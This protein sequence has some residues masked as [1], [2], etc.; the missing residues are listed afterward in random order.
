MSFTPLLPASGIV[1][2]RLLTA[3]E[4][5]QRAAFDRQPQIARDVAYFEEKIGAV[6]T[7][8]DLVSDRRLL[9]VALGAFGLDDE[10]DK[11]AYL[12]R[13]L[14]DGTEASDALANKLVDPRYKAFSKAFGFG[15][16]GG[17]RVARTGF[18]EGLTAA[19]RERQFEIAVGEQDD[20]LRLALNFRREITRHAN[21]P[22]PEGVAWFSV[23]GDQPLRAV[24]EGALGLPT[25]FG[26]LDIDRQRDDLRDKSDRVFGSRSLAIF[27]D[28]EKV[29]EA[30]GRFLARRAAEAGPSPLTPGA[31][32]LTVLQSPGGIGSM[33]MANLVMSAINAR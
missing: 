31:S 26:K 23:M 9:R 21:S 6:K 15:D 2:Y 11:R 12:R 17:V 13:I 25:S 3:T 33:G 29:D 30:I 16:A 4:A 5:V 1:G 20:A 27:K 10:I 7:A 19:Y 24:L 32:A 28:P 8:A 14:E 18:A 22:D